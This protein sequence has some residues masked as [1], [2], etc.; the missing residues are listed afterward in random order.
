MLRN[1]MHGSL[2]L[3]TFDMDAD[4]VRARFECAI[5]NGN[6][7]WL[8]PEISFDEW[9][10]ALIR[11]EATT[12]QILTQGSATERLAGGAKSIGIAA[13]TSGMGPLLGYWLLAGRLKA[14]PPVAALLELHFRHN[15]ER[16]AR[17]ATRA[18][19]IVDGLA[20]RG[21]RVLVI[22]GMQTAFTCFPKPETRSLSDIDLAIRPHD[23]RRAAVALRDMGLVPGAIAPGPPA[24]QTWRSPSA[25]VEPRCLELTHLDNPWSVDL[26]T[27]LDRQ[28]SR[29]SP[30]VRLD[31]L[32]DD[33]TTVQWAL[34]PTG[35]A[36]ALS[37]QAVHLACHASCGISS[38]SM[39]RLCELTL[40][41]GGGTRGDR[42][43]WDEFTD[44]AERFEALP[45]A[46]PALALTEALA[47]G[48][49]PGRVLFEA[50]RG[51]PAAVLRVVGRLSPAT[52]Q[53][54]RRWS[55]QERYMWAPSRRRVALAMVRDLALPAISLA[56]TASIQ[57]KRV[58]RTMRGMLTWF[59]Q[60][61]SR[62][63]AVR[64][65]ASSRS[66]SK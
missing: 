30:L 56:T 22:K 63:V 14:E 6:P 11:I 16:M 66:P 59:S 48:S 54:L 8:W 61:F 58:I 25:R 64:V 7:T 44:L 28:H 62:G 27:S 55:L 34:S 20:E 42:F 57:K 26:Q 13:F 49:V 18:V 32:W 33:R 1:R 12:R 41:F 35:A 9:Q 43:D 24:Q 37:A 47:P 52:G 3:G 51:V 10:D 39:L 53:R 19:G 40:L 65:S 23:H 21:V 15:A 36:L 38:L 2:P 17:M 5:R 45:S 46:Y 29:D 50:R 60:Q 31:G 4:A